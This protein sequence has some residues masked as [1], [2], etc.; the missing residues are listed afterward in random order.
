M[1]VTLLV[2][3]ILCQSPHDGRSSD[4][5]EERVGKSIGES[6]LAVAAA[7]AKTTFRVKL[8]GMSICDPQNSL[9]IWSMKFP[10]ASPKPCTST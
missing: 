2:P 10:D 8:K 6:K 4:N 3:M 5:A 9:L 7:N 1:D